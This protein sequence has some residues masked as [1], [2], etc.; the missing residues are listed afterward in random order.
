MNKNILK[1]V[2]ALLLMSHIAYVG[3]SQES[4]TGAEQAKASYTDNEQSEY[5]VDQD[6]LDNS[7]NQFWDQLLNQ[8]QQSELE[9]E[10][11][12]WQD[13]IKNKKF[14]KNMNKTMILQ[15]IGLCSVALALG[16]G[17]VWIIN[18]MYQ[19]ITNEP[20]LG[21]NQ[22]SAGHGMCVAYGCAG[23]FLLGQAGIEQVV[24]GWNYTK[25]LTQT[26]N[27]RNKN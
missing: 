25:Y 9:R 12:Q 26:I 1:S 5:T 22:P 8:S 17:A 2:S 16:A 23:A 11:V 21:F 24:N 14:L 3:A 6:E 27:D 7:H 15:G 13:A 4:S 18:D 20:N 10:L 19:T